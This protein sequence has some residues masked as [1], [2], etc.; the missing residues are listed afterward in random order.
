MRKTLE[1]GRSSLD[2]LV[3]QPL[4]SVVTVIA[5]MAVLVPWLIGLGISQG[6]VRQAAESVQGGAD[7][8]I[9]GDQFGRSV[10]VPLAAASRIA[11]IDGVVEVVPRIV[12]HVTLGTNQERAV[13]VGMQGRCG[14]K[15]TRCVKGRLFRPR[16]GQELVMGTALARELRLDLGARIPPFYCSSKGERVSTV[17]GLFKSDASPWQSRLIFTS[18][19]TAADVFDQQDRA[20][21]LLVFCRP[22]YQRQVTWA[23]LRGAAPGA[24]GATGLKL[25][26]T[27]REQLEAI[28]PRDLSHR[29]GI[30]NLHFLVAFA[31]GIPLV[32]ITSG[33]GLAERRREVGIL[34]A[35]GWQTD[36]ILLRSVMESLC[37]S[38]AAASASIVVTFA[39]LKAFNGYGIAGVFL[40][41]ASA[42]AAFEVPFQLTPVPALLALIVSVAI[43]MTGT[44][45]SSWRA[46][47][48][49]PMEAMR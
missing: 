23:A 12:G 30:F 39:W 43:V 45:V 6:L 49:A 22:G 27:S 47:I 3:L 7:L 21:D 19:R 17:V 14:R 26:V 42:K 35:V 18:F 2:C 4:R 16:G 20:T 25:R 5:L 11:R 41:G 46:A 9:T 24:N 29:E 40:P 15:G 38:I 37:L 10:P 33:V 8:Y 48:T 1:I 32:L 34:K 31:I 13:L 36:E 44:M 28:L